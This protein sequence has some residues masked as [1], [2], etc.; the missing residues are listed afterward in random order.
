MCIRD[1]YQSESLDGGKSWTQP[2]PLGV[3]GSPPH[4]L[5]HS[6]GVLISAYGRRTPPFGQRV[7]FSTDSGKTW[8][9]DYV[10]RDD[11]PSSDL[12][13]PCSCLLYTSLYKNSDSLNRKQTVVIM[14]KKVSAYTF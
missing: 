13:Y 10:L 2:K 12:G 8:D 7:M 14:Q 6:S 11:G 4:L 3:D 9:V 1:S 5:C